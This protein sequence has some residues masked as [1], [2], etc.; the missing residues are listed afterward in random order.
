[1]G[2]VQDLTTS[3]P[4]Q[5]DWGLPT[6]SPSPVY[7]PRHQRERREAFLPGPMQP[8]RLQDPVLVV[9]R[10]CGLQQASLDLGGQRAWEAGKGARSVIWA[11][12]GPPWGH[13]VLQVNTKD[14]AGLLS[15]VG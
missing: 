9:S 2:R 7:H 8:S 10:L 14:C 13:G 6:P 1:M 3:L 11:T 4:P 5:L 15:G 12:G